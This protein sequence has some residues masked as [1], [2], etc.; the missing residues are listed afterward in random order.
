MP[1]TDTAAVPE[2]LRWS[3]DGC[4]IVAA[5]D[6]VGDRQAFLVM[7][8]VF[9]GVRRFDDM[10]TRTGM[11]RQVLADRLARLV[12]QELLRRHAYREP[13]QRSRQEYRLTPR[14]FDLYPVLVAL[15]D[16]G[17]RYLAGPDGP[18][19]VFEHRGCGGRVHATLRCEHGDEVGG[20]REV[21][22]RPGPGAKP[23]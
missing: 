22:G 14:G 7:R 23:R 5:L 8:E 18:A 2:A 9:S 10:R 1:G 6:V 4:S 21:A 3:T 12:E 16:W 19:V 17:D 15:L 11:P 20:V 13:G